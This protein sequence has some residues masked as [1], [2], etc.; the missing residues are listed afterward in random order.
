MKLF[1]FFFI[2]LL[3]LIWNNN[4]RENLHNIL[5]DPHSKIG[6]GMHPPVSEHLRNLVYLNGPREGAPISNLVMF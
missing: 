6:W 1:V 4:F 2:I 5:I 3:F